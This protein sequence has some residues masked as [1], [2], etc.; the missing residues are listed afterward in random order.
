MTFVDLIVLPVVN[1]IMFMF[2]QLFQSQEFQSQEYKSADVVLREF[3]I[4]LIPH[5]MQ[6]SLFKPSD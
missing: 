1:K 3:V 5:S 4:D 2:L 6:C